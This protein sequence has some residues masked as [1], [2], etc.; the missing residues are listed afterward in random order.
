MD[1]RQAGIVSVLWDIE[2][3]AKYVNNVVGLKQAL[4]S[5]LKEQGFFRNFVRFEITAY[6]DPRRPGCL[7]VDQVD[8]LAMVPVRLCDKGSKKG[9]SDHCLS[10]DC[11]NIAFDVAHCGLRVSCVVVISSD[12]DYSAAGVY[13]GLNDVGIPLIV[14]HGDNVKAAL[15]HTASESRRFVHIEELLERL[16]QPFL[17]TPRNQPTGAGA[18]P[19]AAAP[20]LPHRAIEDSLRPVPGPVA[21]PSASGERQDESNSPGAERWLSPETD[22]VKVRDI[23]I[24]YL[25]QQENGSVKGAQLAIYL[26]NV[27]VT[28]VKLRDLLNAIHPIVNGA[29]TVHGFGQPGD[30]RLQLNTGTAAEAAAAHAASAPVHHESVGTSPAVWLTAESDA[31][32]IREIIAAFLA[33][34][35]GTSRG[36]KVCH[37]IRQKGVLFDKFGDLCR[38]VVGGDSFVIDGLGLEGDLVFTLIPATQERSTGQGYA[39]AAPNYGVLG[40]NL[41]FGA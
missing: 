1:S 30:I 38:A 9:L 12:S 6:H 7:T 24:G 20:P 40:L 29:Y 5:F 33:S 27:H 34:E 3:E 13:D 8:T 28:V 10:R 35:G 18:A 17:P 32:R 19:T 23:I 14:V 36:A 37:H 15:L 41:G 31:D 21:R 25:Q 4:Q 16:P 39:Q 11:R 22:A 2:N 26:R